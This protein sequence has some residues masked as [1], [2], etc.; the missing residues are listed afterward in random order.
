MCIRDRDNTVLRTGS[1]VRLSESESKAS[2]TGTGYYKWLLV[3]PGYSSY[4]PLVVGTRRVP[5]GRT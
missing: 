3:L 4:H 2:H 5:Y 1:R